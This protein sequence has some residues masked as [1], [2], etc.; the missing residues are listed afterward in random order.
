MAEPTRTTLTFVEIFNDIELYLCDRYEHHLR[1]SLARLNLITF[2]TTIPAR[3]EYLS[4]VVGIDQA[5]QV[6]QY[7][8]MFVS[9]A[10][11]RQQYGR[12]RRIV[13]VNRDPGWDENCFA[14][15]H[16]DYVVNDS[17]HVECRGTVG[18]IVRHRNAVSDAR[19]KY[20]QIDR[21]QINIPYCYL[22]DA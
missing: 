13:Y 16:R 7:Q 10:R 21:T 20:F 14:G 9:Q 4:L 6:A 2:R 11:A 3:D 12:E 1:N 8:S 18:R 15:L 5:R 22:I 17:P 19:V